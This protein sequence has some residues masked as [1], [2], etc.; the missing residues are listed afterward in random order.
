MRAS[1]KISKEYNLESDMNRKQRLRDK[2][3]EKQR[4][5]I[6]FATMV[7]FKLLF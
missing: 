5:G 6:G 1:A 3:I 7:K 2:D 4:N